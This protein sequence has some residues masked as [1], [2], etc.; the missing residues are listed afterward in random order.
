[1]TTIPTS[2][3]QQ[4]PSSSSC[5]RLGLFQRWWFWGWL[6]VLAG[7][8][9]GYWHGGDARRGAAGGDARGAS[10]VGVALAR[11]SDVRRYLTGLGSVMP[12]ATATV[13][14][15][16]DGQLMSLHFR[17]GQLVR[18]G[19]LLAELD[20]RPYQIA[21]AQAEGQLARDQALL[22][23]A[24]L[25]LQRYHTLQEQ[26]SIAGQQ[27]DAQAALVKQYEG[28]VKSDQ[29]NLDS[30]NLQ[31]KYAS[32]RAPLS[33]RT[34]LRQVDV[35]N[36]VQASDANGIVVIT[37]LQ[38]ATAVFSIPEDSIPAVMQQLQAGHRLLT[39]AW[40]RGQRN[41][42]AEG[43]LLTIDNQVDAATGTVKLK[44]QFPNTDHALFPNQFVNIRMLLDTL[45]GATVVPGTAIQ[46]G[47]QG[48]FVYVVRQ[49]NTVT[50]RK[51]K[52]GPAEGDV[53]VI[54]DGVVGGET[55]VVD[56]IDRLREGARVEPVRRNGAG[57]PATGN[58]D[59]ST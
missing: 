48:L 6:I 37:Q 50:V 16:V 40:D 55:V 46:R 33:G 26:D 35:G 25:D 1:M 31:L 39:E 10:P 12:T 30:A 47:A 27:V 21:V 43:V 20:P 3:D 45:R 7:G 29:G 4:M 5:A 9:Y 2:S 44:A 38:P 54:E 42:L 24:R 13:R 51:V 15:R 18:E 59:E 32:V 49:D 58:G 34:G 11:T 14:S 41:R 19:D 22:H 23:A 56:G 8:G 52:T 53:T 28:T 36:I 17:E 57:A